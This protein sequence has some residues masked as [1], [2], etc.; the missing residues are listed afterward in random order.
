MAVALPVMI[1]HAIL[2]SKPK[3]NYKHETNHGVK[4]YI[5]N[6]LWS[7]NVQFTA[8]KINWLNPKCVKIIEKTEDWTNQWQC[9]LTEQR[10]MY[11]E[12]KSQPKKIN[13]RN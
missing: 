2:F 3:I 7:Q 9:Y 4:T 13:R 1:C 5:K 8:W 10:I 6:K 11:N 12:Q